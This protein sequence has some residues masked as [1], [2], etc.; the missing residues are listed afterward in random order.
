M[1]GV[2]RVFRATVTFAVMVIIAALVGGTVFAIAT[3]RGDSDT[4][5]GQ[6]DNDWNPVTVAEFVPG[7]WPILLFTTGLTVG[8]WLD[9]G[10]LRR[11]RLPRAR[12]LEIIYDPNDHRYV[13]R[14]FPNGQ[15]KPMTH[16][17]IGIHNG[18]GNRLLQDVVVSPR[19]NAFVKAIIEPAWSGARTRLIKRIEPNA[20]E[21]VELLELADPSVAAAGAGGDKIRRFA[22]RVRAKGARGTSAKFEF[23]P[24]ATPMIRRVV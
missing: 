12:P 11:K 1:A 22:I 23:N 16:F 13:H 19:R 7:F 21:F 3:D 20:T 14:E 15:L 5:I 6:L 24:R 2:F 9:A 4:P 10:A 17:T 8:M 18:T